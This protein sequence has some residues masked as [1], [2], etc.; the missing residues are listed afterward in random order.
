VA[1]AAARR[2]K[3]TEDQVRALVGATFFA[4]ATFYVVSS[5]I[6]MAKTAKGG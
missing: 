2:T 4:L 6:R 3:L 5:A 1:P